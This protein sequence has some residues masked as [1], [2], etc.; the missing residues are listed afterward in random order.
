MFASTVHLI[1]PD[2]YLPQIG[3]N[4]SGQFFQLTQHSSRDATLLLAHG[5][6]FFNNQQWFDGIKSDD[7]LHLELALFYGSANAKKFLRSRDAK[8]SE[9]PSRIFSDSGWAVLRAANSYCFLIAGK[10]GQDGVGGHSHNDKLSI[11]LSWNGQDMIRDAGTYVYT[12]FPEQRNRFRSTAFHNTVTV[13]GQ[14]Q[15]QIVY[16][17]LF[18]LADQAQ[19][20][21]VRHR[22]GK[23]LDVVVAAHS[24]YTR[25]KE[26]VLH[27]R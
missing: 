18:K 21:I 10:N 20:K 22:C 9:L 1:K 15:N 11:V 16:G 14:E 7:A 17:E 19:A 25:L 5:A 3:D 12:A 4:D 26:P 23:N 13:D 8:K 2:G 6:L 24:G 27:R